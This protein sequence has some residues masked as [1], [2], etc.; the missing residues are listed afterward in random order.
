VSAVLRSLDV[1]PDARLVNEPGPLAMTPRPPVKPLSPEEQ[2]ARDAAEA[3][4]AARDHDRW[5]RPSW[6]RGR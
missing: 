5:T 6:R 4:A 1:D 3:A 2:A